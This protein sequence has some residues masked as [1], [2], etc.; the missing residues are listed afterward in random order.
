MRLTLT[1]PPTGSP[2]T[3]PTAAILHAHTHITHADLAPLAAHVRWDA[4]PARAASF[5]HLYGMLLPLSAVTAAYPLT[6]DAAAGAFDGIPDEV[7]ATVAPV[8][9]KE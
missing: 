6:W 2:L 7:P 4:V 5:P 9:P 3:P 1:R 8:A